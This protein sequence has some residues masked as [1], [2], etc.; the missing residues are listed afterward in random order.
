[1]APAEADQQ[2]RL[3]L[4]RPPQLQKKRLQSKRDDHQTER[5]KALTES[6]NLRDSVRGPINLQQLDEKIADL[7]F[8]LTHES[9]SPA[10]EKRM[11]EQKDRLE[12]NDRPSALR[13]A[14]L[15]AKIDAE[16]AAVAEV[17]A[18]IAA[19]DTQL[20]AIKKAQEAEDAKLD[21]I[22]ARQDE[23]RSDIPGLQVGYLL[24]AAA[25]CGVLCV[26]CRGGWWRLAEW[27]GAARPVDRHSLVSELQQHN[28][29]CKR[30]V[31]APRH[32][33]QA[34]CPA[35]AA[36]PRHHLRSVATLERQCL[37]SAHACAQLAATFASCM[38][39]PT[40][41]LPSHLV[42]PGGE[43]GPVGRDPG[44]AAEA[45][46]DPHGIRCPVGRVQEAQRSVEGVGSHRPPQAVREG[47]AG[48][49]G[50]SG[51]SCGSSSSSTGSRWLYACRGADT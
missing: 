23:Q 45:D 1:M 24:G 28:V 15:Q 50:S 22:R 46:R 41:H 13:Y 42:T 31:P 12:K 17:R 21:A 25:G 48:A 37:Q 2:P 30:G 9:L 16:K 6:R 19:L 35:V 8:K 7:E 11:R 40:P 3:A 32:V 20:D 29:E 10:D 5:E 26:P 4:V 51:H 43:E 39:P 49:S 27:F 14:Q 44:A 36:S 47:G 33:L 18:Q 34:N 38:A